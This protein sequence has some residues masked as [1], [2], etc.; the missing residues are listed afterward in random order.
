VVGTKSLADALHAQMGVVEAAVGANFGLP[1]RDFYDRS[2]R[3]DTAGTRGGWG[4]FSQAGME[5][6]RSLDRSPRP[7]ISHS[8]Q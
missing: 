5:R 6:P 2:L 3:D 8:G 1:V 4:A 7:K